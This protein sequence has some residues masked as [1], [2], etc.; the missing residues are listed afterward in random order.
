[1]WWAGWAL[2]VC[3]VGSA[4]GMHRGAGGHAAALVGNEALT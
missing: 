1:M 3:Q 2:I 4:G